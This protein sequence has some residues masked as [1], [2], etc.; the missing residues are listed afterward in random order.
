MHTHL[1]DVIMDLELKFLVKL[2]DHATYITMGDLIEAVSAEIRKEGH[3]STR[4]EVA[5]FTRK[6]LLK[7]YQPGFLKRWLLG[8]KTHIT[9]LL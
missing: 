1:N 7:R 9:S 6:T 8:E 4:E 2:N 5:A 3:H